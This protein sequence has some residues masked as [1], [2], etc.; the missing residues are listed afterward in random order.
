[1]NYASTLSLVGGVLLALSH[2][3][4]TTNE[5]TVLGGCGPGTTMDPETKLCVP[6]DGGDAGSSVDASADGT[7]GPP[8]TGGVSGTGGTAG[9]GGATGGVGAAPHDASVEDVST[10]GTAGQAGVGGTAGDSG[11]PAGS[12]GDAG[13]A[14]GASGVGGGAA[15]AGAGGASG[16]GGEAGFG[17]NGLDPLLVPADPTGKP[18]EVAGQL[19][20]WECGFS[21]PCRI[22]TPTSGACEPPNGSCYTESLCLTCQTNLDCHSKHACYDQKCRRLCKLGGADCLGS[23]VCMNV[24]HFAYGVCVP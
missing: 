11:G 13:A 24:G 17:A 7:G 10:G 5:T 18:C 20:A 8:A 16:G 6:L 22:A 3:C 1:M 15:G 23:D 4:G 21:Q 9:G 14:G 2:G 12:P 19:Y